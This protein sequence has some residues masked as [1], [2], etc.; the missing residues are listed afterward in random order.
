MFPFV[1]VCLFV[2]F[3]ALLSLAGNS[4]PYNWEIYS[5]SK[6]SATHSYQCVQYFPVSKR[7]YGCQCLG[8]L[9]HAQRS[10]HAIAHEGCTDTVRV[11]TES[12]L[13]EKTIPCRTVESNRGLQSASVLRLAFRSHVLP[14]GLFRP[15]RNVA[16][17]EPG[18]FCCCCCCCLRARARVRACCLLYTSPSPRDFG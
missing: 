9:T 1:V 16:E 10:M 2:C 12:W 5:S 17:T 11:C 8:F 14:A 7:W 13:W 18:S 6:S 3:S 15:W 4:G